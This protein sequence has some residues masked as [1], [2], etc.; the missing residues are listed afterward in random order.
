[1]GKFFTEALGHC[2]SAQLRHINVHQDDVRRKLGN[3]A[4]RFL[5]IGSFGDNLEI[6]KTAK[7]GGNTAAHDRMIVGEQHFD[8]ATRFG[9]FRCDL[10]VSVRSDLYRA[11]AREADICAWCG[12]GRRECH[13]HIGQFL[14]RCGHSK[15][16]CNRCNRGKPSL[17]ARGMCGT[18]PRGNPGE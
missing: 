5:A 18:V 16:L 2:Q 11:E 15:S 4:Q 1:V 17:S 14:I 10:S 13:L 8:R 7:A 3:F 12:Y 6:W 9:C